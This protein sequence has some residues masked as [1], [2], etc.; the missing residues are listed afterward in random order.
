VTRV[1]L[2]Q[3]PPVKNEEQKRHLIR[4]VNFI[5][6]RPK[7]ELKQKGFETHH[8]YPKSIAKKNNIDDFDDNWNLIELTSREHFI[9]HI[10]L[11]YCGYKEMTFAFFRIVNCHKYHQS[12]TSRQYEKLIKIQGDILKEKL[13]DTVWVNNG[14]NSKQVK[15]NEIPYGWHIGMAGDRQWINNGIENKYVLTTEKIPEN[16]VKGRLSIGYWIHND[17]EEKY[18]NEDIVPQGYEIGRLLSTTKDT[19]WITN[20]SENKMIPKDDSVHDGWKLG[21]TTDVKNYRLIT[22]GNITKYLYD[23][24]VMPEGWEYGSIQKKQYVTWIN[25]GELNKRWDVSKELPDGFT[26]GRIVKGFFITNGKIA[27]KVNSKNEIP[28]GWRKGRLKRTKE[29]IKNNLTI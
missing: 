29:Q 11:F 14:L 8:I 25:N 9:A 27:K 5:N 7:R 19:K 18:T 2:E 4:Y 13:T 12:I 26:L 23:G 6:S 16:F 22:N 17:N 28:F 24:E 20:G 3:M 15:F 10:I 21:M 1:T